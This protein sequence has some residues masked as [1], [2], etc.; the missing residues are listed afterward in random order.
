MWGSYQCEKSLVRLSGDQ[1]EREHY[2]LHTGPVTNEALIGRDSEDCW[3]SLLYVTLVISSW[4]DNIMTALGSQVTKIS[5][6]LKDKL[7]RIMDIC[8]SPPPL[9]PCPLPDPD[10]YLLSDGC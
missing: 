2:I 8:I 3:Q 6:N 10:K 9:L 1:G 4:G 5:E 7:D